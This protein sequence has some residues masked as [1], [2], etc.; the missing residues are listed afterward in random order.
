[1]RYHI[2]LK[3]ENWQKMT[4]YLI[5]YVG[6]NS[7]IVDVPDEKIEWLKM[8]VER[9][10]PD[11]N[12]NLG[13][14]FWYNLGQLQHEQVI[15]ATMGKF[16]LCPD[17][18]YTYEMSQHKWE[19]GERR[20]Q[21]AIWIHCYSVTG[22][23]AVSDVLISLEKLYKLSRLVG[24]PIIIVG[25]MISELPYFKENSLAQ[26][27][28]ESYLRKEE[29]L[30]VLQGE[31]PKQRK[32][33]SCDFKQTEGH[34]VYTNMSVLRLQKEIQLWLLYKRDET[35]LSRI[36][37]RDFTLYLDLFYNQIPP[38][39][40][41]YLPIRTLAYEDIDD[42]HQL[43]L[44][45]VEL[46]KQYK[47]IYA[48][49]QVLD[50][51]RD[52]LMDKVYPNF[53]SPILTRVP[54]RQE[55]MALN[56]EVP[57]HLESEYTGKDVYIGIITEEGIDY[58]RSCLKTIQ[59]KTRIFQYW[60]QAAENQGNDYTREQIDEALRYGNDKKLVPLQK[61]ENYTTTLLALAGGIGEG[62][63]SIA[64]NAQ[65]LVAQIKKA[66]KALQRLYGGGIE[67]NAVL[68][69]DVL[70]A[71]YKLL[72]IAQKE[73]KPIVLIIPYNTNLSAHDGTGIYE[74]M[75]SEL[76]KQPGCTLII[77]A[78]EEA[79]RQHHQT[80][81]DEQV[82]IPEILM[83][84]S[85]LTDY[86]VGNIY[87]KHAKRGA[88][89][90]YPPGD[91]KIGFRLDEEGYYDGEN[92]SVY[93][94]GI[95]EDYQNGASMIRFQIVHMKPGEWQMKY[96][97]NL[98]QKNTKIDM[99][100]AQET[101]NPYVRLAPA[102]STMTIGSNAALAD[103]L[104][105]GAYD[106]KNLVLLAASGRGGDWDGRFVP[107]C[108]MEGKARIVKDEEDDYVLE[109]TAV[110]AG[111]LAGGI[112]L[113]HEKWCKKQG[114]PYAN[115]LIMRNKLLN[116]MAEQSRISYP[117]MGYGVIRLRDLL[118]SLKSD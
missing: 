6:E 67:S 92:G 37:E 34:L 30:I 101:L 105:V 55:D 96:A 1:M 53:E 15:I 47:M 5:K 28:A 11:F 89:T 103:V 14:L 99:W 2:V 100:L 17:I 113:I 24:K 52:L 65:F 77:P 74:Q 82:F 79:H 111:F 31:F 25:D 62:Y 36:T 4:P 51:N 98:I 75:L 108:V 20:N 22:E 86:L 72:G 50:L 85:Q 70:I 21:E 102:T 93:T 41:I 66:P 114:M 40:S 61:G 45:T 54:I 12:L 109:G 7:A 42:Y 95:Q 33:Q 115:T 32:L 71:G 73:K 117:N 58:T 59:G 29:S 112:A 9:I 80:I 88:I 10:E 76:A 16:F 13:D 48:K 110:A 46:G 49:K 78:G 81:A 57:I 106:G 35:I 87:L 3:P 60:V 69:P 118:N 116:S 107:T 64:T 23:V 56:Q 19:A 91:R 84:G 39:Q 44:K 83:R 94:T 97:I 38:T 68:M 90:L 63:Q 26:M 18:Q 104:S 8:Q 43:G 27:I